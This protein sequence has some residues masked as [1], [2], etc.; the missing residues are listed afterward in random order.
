L[1]WG[2]KTENGIGTARIDG[3]H[4]HSSAWKECYQKGLSSFL[5]VPFLL[6]NI[7]PTSVSEDTARPPGR[8]DILEELLFRTTCDMAL[9]RNLK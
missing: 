6:S 8:N 4:T 5:M 3:K 2:T 1:L 9:G 7:P